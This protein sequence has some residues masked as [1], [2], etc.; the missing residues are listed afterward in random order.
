MRKKKEKITYIDDGRSIADMSAVS[1]GM[2]ILRGSA[3]P[4]NGTKM[5]SHADSAK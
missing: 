3:I 4:S 2:N 1:G 5:G